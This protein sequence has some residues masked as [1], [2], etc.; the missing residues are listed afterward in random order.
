MQHKAQVVPLFAQI[1]LRARSNVPSIR[2][3]KY[4][5][6]SINPGPE[7]SGS[8]ISGTLDR[9]APCGPCRSNR[10]T[11][12]IPSFNTFL[13][14]TSQRAGPKVRYPIACWRIRRIRR[15]RGRNPPQILILQGANCAGASNRAIFSGRSGAIYQMP[16]ALPTA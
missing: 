7:L 3:G 5:G 4:L 15:A 10:T 1:K 9:V 12:T 16:N 13:V 2:V 6:V 8:R 11:R 14:K